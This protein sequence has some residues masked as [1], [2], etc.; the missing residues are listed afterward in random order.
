MADTLERAV[1]AY[2][3][4]GAGIPVPRGGP[5]RRATP[6]CVIPGNDTGGRPR[7]TYASLLLLTDV[8]NG[9]PVG[10]SWP[11]ALARPN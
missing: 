6:F 5:G 4:E 11:M 2:V 1:R 7:D 9:Y 10:D 8:P 3:A